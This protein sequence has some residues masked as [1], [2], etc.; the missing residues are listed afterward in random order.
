MQAPRV[1]VHTSLLE[2]MVALTRWQGKWAIRPASTILRGCPCTARALRA[3][4][5]LHPPPP[6][7]GS[8][9]PHH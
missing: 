9:H 4:F 5:P 7:E 2:A 8:H 1:G 3:T 6:E